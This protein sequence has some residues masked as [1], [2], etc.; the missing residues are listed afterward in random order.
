MNDETFEILRPLLGMKQRDLLSTA[1]DDYWATEWN[2]IMRE[3]TGRWHVTSRDRLVSEP[4]IE[5]VALDY[6]RFHNKLIDSLGDYRLGQMLR[7]VRRA[8]RIKAATDEMEAATAAHELSRAVFEQ[9]SDRIAAAQVA[10]DE[11]KQ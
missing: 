4:M 9:T 6:C 1:P 11:A 2:I 10:L 8:E 7:I 3:D 5:P